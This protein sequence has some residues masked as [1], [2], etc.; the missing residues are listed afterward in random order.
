MRKRRVGQRKPVGQPSKYT[1][2]EGELALWFSCVKAAVR[3]WL[4][5]SPATL[6]RQPQGARLADA[7]AL[8]GRD[9]DTVRDWP[10]VLPVT[11]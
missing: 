11:G 8:S 1:S 6:T 7:S 9:S 3:I 4:E 5:G 10:H 2:R